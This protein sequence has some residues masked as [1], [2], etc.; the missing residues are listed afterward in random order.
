[1]GGYLQGT[2]QQDYYSGS[3]YGDYQYLSLDEVIDNHS[4]FAY[5]FI[6]LLEENIN[7]INATSMFEKLKKTHG[8]FD[9]NPKLN[10]LENIGDKN[11]DFFFFAK[12]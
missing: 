9:Q 6:R 2:T 7:Y 8:S 10:R 1:M 5:I 4:W 12:N 11:G 3:T